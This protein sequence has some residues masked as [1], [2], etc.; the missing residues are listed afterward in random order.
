MSRLIA[1]IFACSILLSCN[2]DQ[3]IQIDVSQQDKADDVGNAILWL[4]DGQW[5]PKVFTSQ[6][7]DLFKGLDTA[8]LSGTSIPDSITVFTDAFFPNPFGSLA[9]VMIGFSNGFTGQVA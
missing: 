6:E 2:K 3:D 7:Q 4:N 1:I 8:N 9:T 5:G